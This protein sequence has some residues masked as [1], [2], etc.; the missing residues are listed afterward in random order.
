MS[1][2]VVK[3]G[4]ALGIGVLALLAGNQLFSSAAAA[5]GAQIWGSWYVTFAPAPGLTLP[6]VVTINQ[7][8]TLT[9]ADA[10]DF[11]QPP[12]PNLHSATYGSWVRREDGAFEAV[13]MFLIYD[14]TGS[15]VG[16]GR[17]LISFRFGD[18]FDQITGV[19]DGQRLDCP[20]AFTCPDPFAA[21]AA[22]HADPAFPVPIPFQGRR[23]R[24]NLP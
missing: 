10:D 16:I 3:A 4:I 8:G 6:A 15:L 18:D 1:I 24:G 20:T 17:N 9:N 21:S 23:I 19:A 2:S 12:F 5:D 14:A 22:W 11:A 7:E 13:G